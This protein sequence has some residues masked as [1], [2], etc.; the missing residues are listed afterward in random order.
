MVLGVCRRILGNHAD[1]DDAFQATFLVLV[2]K[3]RSLTSRLVIGDWLHGVARR[4]ALKAMSAAGRRRIVERNAVCHDIP[5]EEARNDWLPFLDEELSRLP[6]KY[7]LPIVLCDLEGKTRRQAAQQLTWPEGTVAGRLARGRELLAK[8]LLN[9][10][11]SAFLIG[12]GILER[13]AVAALPAGLLHST[14]Q[15]ASAAAVGKI[16]TQVVSAGAL[17]LA[18]GVVRAMFWS[19]V[20]TVCVAMLA[21][22]VVAGAGGETYRM[23]AGGREVSKHGGHSASSRLTDAAQA[24]GELQGLGQQQDQKDAIT[25]FADAANAQLEARNKEFLEGKVAPELNSST[26]W[27]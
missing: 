23:V 26:F 21:T 11:Q 8:R 17:L 18:K 16:T 24:T 19:K 22:A 14:V 6:E 27:A 9:S 2:R 10:A 15:A 20:K 4:T 5:R 13:G 12:P 1:A 3:A 25:A 7:R